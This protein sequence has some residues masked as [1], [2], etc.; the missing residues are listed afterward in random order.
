MVGSARR[1]GC[2][3]HLARYATTTT[4][5][6]AGSPT[7]RAESPTAPLTAPR[8][9]MNA[10]LCPFAWCSGVAGLVLHDPALKSRIYPERV[11]ADGDQG[12]QEPFDPLAEQSPRRTGG[13]QE[14][15]VQ[16]CVSALPP[17]G[18]HNR[19]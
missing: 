3:R 18:P 19:P 8:Q 16:D 17:I 11:D 6:R 9:G 1:C 14:A 7:S 10:A 15:T 2:G 12:Q 4:P 13:P 5:S